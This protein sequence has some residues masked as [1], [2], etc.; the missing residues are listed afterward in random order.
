M[1]HVFIFSTSRRDLYHPAV[2]GHTLYFV[3][4]TVFCSATRFPPIMDVCKPVASYAK[5]STTK[6]RLSFHELIVVHHGSFF[7]TPKKNQN[8]DQ[9]T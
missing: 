8:N 6:L 4:L 2:V 7:F 9:F 5:H 3:L 1:A